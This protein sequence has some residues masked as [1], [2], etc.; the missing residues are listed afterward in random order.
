[1]F[2]L[3]QQKNKFPIFIFAIIFIIGALLRFYNPNWDLGH[4]LHP[5]ERLY[6]NASNIKLPVSWQEFFSPSSPLNPHMFYYGSLPL[7]L[8]VGIYNMLQFQKIIIDLLPLSR[9]VSAFFS[10]LTIF[11]L[12]KLARKFLSTSGSLIA[13]A[14]F[15]FSVGSIQYS[16]YNTTES[17]LTFLIVF[18]TY[19]SWQMINK[20]IKSSIF[21]SIALGA[22]IGTAF[23]V[24][25]TGL[26]FG[27][28]PFIAYLL[29]FINIV[30]SKDK[31][32]VLQIFKLI[33]HGIILLFFA[34]LVGF[35]GAPYNFVDFPSF[36]REQEY[37]QGVT[38]GKYKPPFVIIY[39]YTI[40]YLYQLT[41]IFP[42]IFSPFTLFI[43][44]IGL[45]LIFFQ[46]RKKKNPALLLILVWPLTYFATAGLWFTK[47]TRYMIPLLPF[48][49]FFAAYFFELF[50]KKKG[51][52]KIITT[53]FLIL[54][55]SQAIYSFIFVKSIY[56]NLNTRLAASEWI[57]NNIPTGS[58]I[59]TEHWDDGLPAPLPNY[60]RERYSYLELQVYNPDDG[61]KINTLISQ[62]S[63]AD[64]IIFSSRRVFYSILR[65][66]EKYPFT[67]QFYKK[68]FNEQ[69]GFKLIKNEARFPD[70]AAD[71]SFQSYDHP[72]VY[73]F[74]NI[75]RL[76]NKLL[77][78]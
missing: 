48:L 77:A 33:V 36:Y 67:S 55:T 62:I 25:I 66:P 8:Y 47:F 64:Y 56:G 35:F 17:L 23:A 28:T 30:K 20:S 69:L 58:I 31:N 6:V 75:N 32:K 57:F 59:A 74:K 9:M 26:S 27:I 41:Q 34:C 10:T 19:L 63:A 15:S 73:I 43:S 49:S 72:P 65:N 52:Q 54:I 45:L 70:N 3:L 7:Y 71:E 38:L 68:L 53:T 18:I 16:H 60:P 50:H 1:M 46:F 4:Y 12:Y 42:W 29:I 76:N 13:S 21:L 61:F 2:L 24:K 51:W 37:M 44:I 11:V 22:L 14:F 39:E 78:K 5:D 40:P